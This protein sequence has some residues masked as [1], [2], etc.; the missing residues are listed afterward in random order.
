MTLTERFRR[1][2]WVGAVGWP[3]TAWKHASRWLLS[4]REHNVIEY[5]LDASLPAETVPIQGRIERLTEPTPALERFVRRRY[6]RWSQDQHAA[7]RRMR[8]RFARGDRCVALAQAEEIIAHLWASRSMFLQ[9]ELERYLRVQPDEVV[10]YDM[11]VLPPYRGQR[12]IDAL[13]P[14]FARECAQAGK[15][16]IKM[17]VYGDNVPSLRVARRLG[18]QRVTFRLWD[19]RLFGTRWTSIQATPSPLEDL[20]RAPTR[21][22][23]I[24]RESLG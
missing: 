18:F 6:W 7:L 9:P 12:C 17:V 4:I 11:F 24:A 21:R 16:A 13:F 1:A 8:E 14:S 23:Q 22:L 19:V 3:L 15:R 10:L 2:L 20:V 5:A